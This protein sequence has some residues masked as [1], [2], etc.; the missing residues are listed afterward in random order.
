MRE[1]R[2]LIAALA[3]AAV[4][5]VICI[6]AS[7]QPVQTPAFYGARILT[8]LQVFNTL[9][10]HFSGPGC[11]AYLAAMQPK[12]DEQYATV[13]IPMLGAFEVHSHHFPSGLFTVRA[14]GPVLDRPD[15]QF[16]PRYQG[17]TI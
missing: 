1:Q 16:D 12:I 4:V 14:A 7:L 17:P 11:G 5:G 6:W 15:C 3:L 8:P 13:T 9:E 10:K 2:A